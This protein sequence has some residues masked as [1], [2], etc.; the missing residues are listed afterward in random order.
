MNRILPGAL[1]ALLT[2]RAA[3]AENGVLVDHVPRGATP[4]VVIAVCKTALTNRAW[5]VVAVGANFV[6]AEI[7]HSQT[8]ARIHLSFTEWRVLYEGSAIST[9]RTGPQQ[10][11]TLRVDTEIPDRWITYLRRDVS[12]ALATIPETSR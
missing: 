3:L 11:T 1:L 10:Q 2:A 8:K 7:D 9:R 4:D 6:D 12:T 5:K